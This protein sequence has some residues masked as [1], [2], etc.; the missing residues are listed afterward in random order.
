MNIDKPKGITSFDV[1][2][3]IRRA[4]GIRKVGHA[5]T[6]DPN[7]TGVLPVAIGEAT[8]LVDEL[9][10][11]RKRYLAEVVFGVATDS[12]DI[13]GQVTEEHDAST[14][15][16]EAVRDA[17]APYDGVIMQRPPAFSA[18]KRAGVAAYTAARKG[19][20][21]DLE[22]RPVTIYGVEVD[23][24]DASAP[25]RPRIVLDVRCGRGF[26]VRSLAHDLGQTLG[27][28]A[29]LAELRR[30]Q[31]GPFTADESTPLETAVALLAAGETDRLVHAPDVVLAG[32]PAVLIGER[33]VARIRQGMDI[34]ALPRVDYV[35]GEQGPR[36]RC[37]G[38]DGALIALLEPGLAVGTWHPFRVFPAETQ[39]QPTPQGR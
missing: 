1:I 12:Y 37:Y 23:S 9:M 29:H 35:R 16:I 14:L 19:E 15:T 3:R 27:V 4:S 31:V 32:W 8:R 13:D 39:S 36:A 17:L 21:L 30:T 2:R 25:S 22:E 33:E 38:P 18:V 10:D 34:T 24:W 5:G 28:G 11:A 6:L 26:Y 7:A 20:P